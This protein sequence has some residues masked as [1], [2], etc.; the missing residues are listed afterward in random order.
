M[1]TFDEEGE[2]EDGQD[3]D[4]DK[5]HEVVLRAA[6]APAQESMPHAEWDVRATA[7]VCEAI[8]LLFSTPQP[9]NLPVPKNA[10]S[11]DAHMQ[12]T[13]SQAQSPSQQTKQ[14]GGDLSTW[15]NIGELLAVDEDVYVSPE[16]YNCLVA[17]CAVR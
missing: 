16:L 13:S 4:G 15:E 3:E 2:D 7:A 1:S 5:D 12:S 10:G 6:P 8:Y 11:S 17:C 14:A 9:G